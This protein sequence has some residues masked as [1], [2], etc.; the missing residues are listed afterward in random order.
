MSDAITTE[1]LTTSEVAKRLKLTVSGVRALVR[2]GRIVPD[3]R[4]KSG[5]SLAG[6]RFRVETIEAFLRGPSHE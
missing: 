2:R 1:W 4:G 5:A 6:H 3:H